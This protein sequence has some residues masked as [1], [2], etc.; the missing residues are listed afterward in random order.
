M[1][2]N[3]VKFLPATNA[4]ADVYTKATGMP[5]VGEMMVAAA[6]QGGEPTPPTPTQSVWYVAL[7]D[8]KQETSRGTGRQTGVVEDE[9]QELEILTNNNYP[10][11]VGQMAW[12][13]VMATVDD[14]QMWP[15]QMPKGTETGL[16]LLFFSEEPATITPI[17]DLNIEFMGG[18][19]PTVS[20]RA[21]VDYSADEIYYRSGGVDIRLKP[22]EGDYTQLELDNDY[23]NQFEG[24]DSTTI[25]GTI[26]VF[27][28]ELGDFIAE[29]ELQATVTPMF[30]VTDISVNQNGVDQYSINGSADIAP[31][32]MFDDCIAEFQGCENPISL[33]IGDYSGLDGTYNGVADFQD[34]GTVTVTDTH[35]NISWT[36]TYTYTPLP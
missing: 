16:D 19:E 17:Y 5:I 29:F 7:G 12:V 27:S 6:G 28:P 22:M 23:T 11:L 24:I 25:Y 2:L 32:E 36:G 34:G 1:K 3:D 18:G 14:N 26:Q 8:T 9:M 4:V 33:Y 35:N 30:N 31:R 15:M 13:S 20:A 21:R 10:Q